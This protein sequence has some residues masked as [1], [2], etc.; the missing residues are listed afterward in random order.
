MQVQD[1]AIHNAGGLSI[2]EYNALNRCWDA[3]LREAEAALGINDALLSDEDTHAKNR[4]AQGETRPCPVCHEMAPW[5]ALQ[6]KTIC[7]P[8]EHVC[9]I[10]QRELFR[11]YPA[12][13]AC[14]HHG[15]RQR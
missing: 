11:D 8:D 4:N 15:N 3:Y 7:C 12:G 9:D 14:T 6:Q 2:D 13:W 5:S 10:C 1:F